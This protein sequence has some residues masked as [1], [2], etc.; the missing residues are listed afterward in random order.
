MTVR[1][2]MA[3]RLAS[4][5]FRYPGA[6]ESRA[7][8][9]LGWTPATFWLKVN[10]LLDRPDVEAAYPMEVHRLRRLRDGRRRQRSW[11]RAS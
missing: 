4:Q 8:D 2:H 7:L 10:A 3:I 6:R 11:R 5:P 9:E 1:E